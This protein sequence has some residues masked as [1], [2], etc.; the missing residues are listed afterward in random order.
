MDHV[1]HW[2]TGRM[3][4]QWV[5]YSTGGIMRTQPQTDGR[6]DACNILRPEYSLMGDYTMPH[7]TPTAPCVKTCTKCGETK[8]ATTEY[9][10]RHKRCKGGVRSCCKVCQSERD[11]IYRAAHNDQRT[12]Q[13]REWRSANPERNRANSRARYAANPERGRQVARAWSAANRERHRQRNQDWRAANPAY[14]RA[15]RAANPEMTRAHN[16]TRRARKLGAGGSHSSMDI[17]RQYKA[18]RGRCYYAACGYSKL[19][20]TYHVDHIVPL[21]RGGSDAPENLVIACP[22]CNQSKHNK[23]PHE[24][25][26]GGRLL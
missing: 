5:N 4:R 13:M 19:G 3:G 8:P 14:K 18:Q 23:L 26:E 21:S 16:H 9:F 15:Y 7:S 17:T 12:E 6:S 10:A 11:R 25:I 1:D 2:I 24:W 20:E 22:R